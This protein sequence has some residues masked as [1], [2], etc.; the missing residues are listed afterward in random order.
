VTALFYYPT[1]VTA[2]AAGH[3][4]VTSAGMFTLSKIDADPARTVY[5]IVTGEKNANDGRGDKASLSVHL[6][7]AWANGALIASDPSVNRI[8]RVTPD[9]R[10]DLTMISTL[11]G[12]GH[13]GLV[14]G[15]GDAASFAMPFGLAVG[16]DGTI[17][18]ADTGNGAV[19][20]IQQ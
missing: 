9:P 1:D 5:I 2:D 4:Y 19:R 8:R 7:L 10:P 3:I 11:A 14:D 18:V 20:A 12:R 17:Y 15:A 16:P 6:G 13:Y